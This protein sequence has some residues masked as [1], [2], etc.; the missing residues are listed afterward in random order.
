MKGDLI[1]SGGFRIG[2]GEV[3]DALLTHPAVRE[4]AVLGRPNDDLG[5]EIV[6]FVVADPV[7]ADALITHVATTLSKHKRPRHVVF[8]DALPR[9]HMGKIQKHRLP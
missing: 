6:A 5:E 1:K 7:T 3:E 2:A 8:L 4:A 9:N